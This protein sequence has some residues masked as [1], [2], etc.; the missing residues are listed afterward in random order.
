MGS[1]VITCWSD[2]LYKKIVYKW[3][4]WKMGWKFS[5]LWI[6]KILCK[7]KQMCVYNAKFIQCIMYWHDF[8]NWS[9][10]LLFNMVKDSSSLQVEQSSAGWRR[11]IF[12]ILGPQ[13]PEAF[14]LLVCHRESALAGLRSDVISPKDW[15]KVKKITGNWFLSEHI[16]I[17]RKWQ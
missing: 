17:V 3:N 11:T 6:L 13:G 5:H 4:I 8:T 2:F 1:S 16:L 15:S 10:K 12:P 9:P 14:F 7:W